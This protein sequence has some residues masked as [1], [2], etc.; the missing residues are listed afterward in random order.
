MTYTTESQM[1]PDVMEWLRER[2]KARYKR[3]NV[4][5]FDTHTKYLSKFLVTENLHLFFDDYLSY[6]IKVDIIGVI[7]RKE[8]AKLIFVE[9]KLAPITL[10][11]ISQLLGYSKV[12]K[13]LSSVVIS[14]KGVSKSVAYLFNTLRRYDILYYDRD[15]KIIIA[16]WKPASKDIVSSSIIPRGE[17]L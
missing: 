7:K 15:K 16:Q 4:S 2:L 17:H 3:Y 9:C 10:R 6:E 1:Y 12:A 14:P 13:P 11:D 5:V 8:K